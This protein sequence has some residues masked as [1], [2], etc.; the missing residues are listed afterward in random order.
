MNA[1][2]LPLTALATSLLVAVTIFALPEEARRLRTTINI[3]AAVVKIILVTLMVRRVAAGHEDIFS[4]QVIGGLDFVLRIDA[5]GVMFAGLSSLLWLCTTIYA[6]GYLEGSANRKRFFGFFSLCVAS[7]IGIALADNLFTFLIFYEML[8]LSTYP[9]VVHRGTEKALNAGRVYLRYTL[10]AGVVLL[11]GAVLLNNL[12]GDQS[13]SSE[14]G[15]GD[16][17]N[18]HRGLL[19]LIFILLVSGLA[20]KAAMV[21]LHGWLPRAM[22]APA[23]VSA[24]LHAVAVV[25]AGAFGILRVVYDLYGIELS[26]ELGVITGLAVAASI[27]I[28]YGSLRAIAQ[29][30]LKP[31]LA[32]STVSQVSYV[33]LGIGIFGPFG[34]VGALAHLLHQGLMKVTLFFCAGNYA[35]E[36]GIHRIDEIDG[37]GKRMP[38][39]SIAFTIGALGMI[40]LP[41]VAGFITKWYLG[42]GAIQAE[43]YWVVAVLVASSTLNAM[44]FLPILHRL[45]FRPGPSH[46]KGNWP[47]E[48]RLGRLETH[49]WLLW[50]MMFTALISLGAGLFAG[51]PYSP[52]DWAARVAS[53][54]YL[55]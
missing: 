52:L 37:A 39:T 53:G 20:V 5:L 50:P 13:F 47:H 25:K 17:L 24:L 1:A 49:G 6:I 48:Q 14:E 28:I 12:T 46:G 3:G 30:E 16:Y 32:F 8:T 44:Y 40:G 54:G 18:D 15:L 26:V 19:T 4:F 22:V 9:L 45:W 55:P 33:I 51:L 10:S 38:L 23:P 2:W 11:L 42:V 34:T 43:M 41:P 29:Q 36:L 21:P 27:T 7:T 31:L 35:E